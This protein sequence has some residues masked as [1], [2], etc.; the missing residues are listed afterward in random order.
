MVDKEII[1]GMAHSKDAG[2]ELFRIVLLFFEE[3][4][5][6]ITLIRTDFADTD[7]FTGGAEG[8]YDGQAVIE[9]RV[10]WL[11]MGGKLPKRAEMGI[12]FRSGERLCNGNQSIYV[13]TRDIKVHERS[14]DHIIN[15]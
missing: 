4:L 6:L 2:E 5:T 10:A 3:F 9:V 7:L 11:E 12:F 1:A 13:S 14:K 15:V 8:G